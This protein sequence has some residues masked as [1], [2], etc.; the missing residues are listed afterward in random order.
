MKK[1]QTQK[2]IDEALEQLAAALANGQS[3]A[4]TQYLSAMAKFSAYS[5]GNLLLI[6]A[7]RPEATRVA[8]YRTWQGLGRY[9]KKSEKGILITAPIVF[10]KKRGD[11]HSRAPPIPKEE[12]TILLFKA[13]HVF[14]ISQTDGKPLPDPARVGG[15]PDG[16]TEKLKAFV[17]SKG[18]ALDYSSSLG[19]ADGRSL[20]RRITLRERL[21]PAEE[22]SVL[23]HEIAHC[24]LHC[25]GVATTRTVCETEAEAVAFVACQ[26]IGLET[27]SSSSDYI[28]IYR[29]D[30]GT[31]A[32]SLDRIQ[33]TTSAILEAITTGA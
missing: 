1:N 3:E 5:L 32:Q 24:L 25:R 11:R 9:V 13:V 4:L 19:T 15:N 22:F 23:V 29:G 33:K 16:H 28:Q 26:A 31:F 14:D 21:S 6:L 18:I 30:K 7:Q 12:D 8:G 2:V 10:S 17:A 27:G 20:G